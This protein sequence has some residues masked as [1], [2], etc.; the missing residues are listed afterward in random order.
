[1]FTPEMVDKLH[2]AIA[3]AEKARVDKARIHQA[4]QMLEKVELRLELEASIQSRKHHG[5]ERNGL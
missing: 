3:D 5:A 4:R 1:M 2:A